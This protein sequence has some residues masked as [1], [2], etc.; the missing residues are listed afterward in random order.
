MFYSFA[1]GLLG[2]I[3]LFLGLKSEGL[4][5]LPKKGSVIIASNHISNWDPIMVALVMNRPVHFMA[6]IELFANPILAWI[7][8]HANAFPVKRGTADRAAIRQALEVLEQGNVLGIFP[9]GVRN[10]SGQDMKAQA[11]VAML[12]LKSGS[13]VVPVACVGT[14]RGLPIGWF[15]PLKVRI[16][17]PLSLEK[18]RGQKLNSALLDEV[19]S[20]I[21]GEINNLLSK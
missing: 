12:A 4:H 21:M 1:R 2:A 6:K 10:R 3:F 19:S 9:E 18:Y 17:T 14:R 13:P 20:E 15:S 8:N 16:G 11:G 7:L 5:N